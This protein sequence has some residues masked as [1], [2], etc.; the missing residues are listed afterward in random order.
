MS[1][2]SLYIN[3]NNQPIASLL[4]RLHTYFEDVTKRS[5][6]E[7]AHSYMLKFRS[8]ALIFEIYEYVRISCKTR[9]ERLSDYFSGMTLKQCLQTVVFIEELQTELNDICDKIEEIDNRYHGETDEEPEN[10]VLAEIKCLNEKGV[11]GL[12]EQNHLRIAPFISDSCLWIAKNKEQGIYKY[13]SIFSRAKEL[14]DDQ[15]EPEPTN[16]SHE[17]EKT[18]RENLLGN[19]LAYSVIPDFLIHPE[20]Q[21]ETPFNIYNFIVD[22]QEKSDK[23]CFGDI[24][25]EFRRA[26]ELLRNVF[27]ADAEDI[28][29]I[30]TGD[31][32]KLSLVLPEDVITH[33]YT[34]LPFK[35]YKEAR[36]NYA[37]EFAS[38]IENDKNEWRIKKGY[39]SRK[40][41]DLENK[42]YYEE[43]KQSIINEM[44]SYEALW[45]LR[46]HSGG[47]DNDVTPDNFARMFFRRENGSYFFIELQW[48]LEIIESEIAKLEKE[49]IVKD[50][51][52]K[53]SPEE[54][55]VSDFISK[56]NRLA[57]L[58]S[59]KWHGKEVSPGVH[60]PNLK[61]EVKSL[62]LKAFLQKEQK[63]NY[64][65]LLS[66][67]F[68]PSSKTKAQF[69]QYI[70]KIKN[71]YFV[72]LPDKNIAEVLAPIV[73]LKATSVRNYL[74]QYNN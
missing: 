73:E 60:K 29:Y 72:N 26:L 43:K 48:Q 63:D 17:A 7:K 3:L 27:M 12:S 56:I 70:N 53:L 25:I 28:F 20:G 33:L 49:S 24:F 6:R 68:P 65:E 46:L 16:V 66:I 23:A 51:S 64:D 9:R 62:E 47:L 59:D 38:E 37:R 13:S 58:L 30:R 57:E 39:Y 61:V 50:S 2:N 19:H 21:T 32:E 71:I 14:L 54:K 18:E 1:Y 5:K 52:M 41:T 34:D 67:C 42:E 22:V 35:E 36:Y 40:L 45:I 74:A 69:C 15:G 31:F 10:Y 55:A 4:E 44:K 8:L 11:D